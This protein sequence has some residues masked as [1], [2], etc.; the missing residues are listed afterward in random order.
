M[1]AAR[2]V[3]LLRQDLTAWVD[4]SGQIHFKEGHLPQSTGRDTT[5]SAPFPNDETFRLHSRAG[6]QRVIFLDFDGHAVS[7]TAW[8]DNYA[9]STNVQPRF[10]LDGSPGTWNQAEHDAIQSVF[11]RVAED[12]APFDV[13]VTTEDPGDAALHRS[14]S[15]DEL[16][17]TR[18]LITP[19]TEAANAIC[20]GGCGGWAYLS[21]YNYVTYNTYYQPAWVF[22][23]ALLNDTKYIAEAVSHEAGHNLGLSHDGTPAQGYYTGHHNWAPIM[24]V[25]YYE[26]LVQWS[27]GE[28]PDANNTED[29][30]AVIQSFGL[31]LRPDDHG[32]TTGAARALGTGTSASGQIETRADKDVFSISRA[33][34]ASTTI[35]V[36]TAPTSPNLDAK[37]RVLTSSGALVDKSDPASGQSSG[38]VATGLSATFTGN[39]AATTYYLEVSGVGALT[40]TTGYSDYG[41]LGQY[42]LSITPCAVTTNLLKNPSF[43]NDTNADGRPDSWTSKA[44]FTRDSTFRFAGTYSGKHRATDNSNHTINQTV[45]GI[46]AGASYSFSGQVLIPA[47][48]DAFTYKLQ[49]RWINGS[50]GTIRTDTIKTYTA[51]TGGA[52]NAATATKVAPTGAEKAQVRLVAS[53]LNATIYI[54]N[55]LFGR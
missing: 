32:S 34:T 7:G 51:A 49:I 4:S 25:G 8:N 48:S 16:Y 20:G 9:I 24:G 31:P 19:S 50:G 36:R 40:T 52:W 38:D 35:E 29:D 47:T 10:D 12:F 18:V 15:T 30:V 3:A 13:D 33:C 1:S 5:E 28:Y 44:K 42:S 21:I 27:R 2:F 17:G 11:H 23:H 6:S 55:L 45:T 41:S 37:L 46:T 26:P 43:E 22:T 53:N 14:A 54:D 39:L